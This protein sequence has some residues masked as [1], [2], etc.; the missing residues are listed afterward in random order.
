MAKVATVARHLQFGTAVVHPTLGNAASQWICRAPAR[1]TGKANSDQ[2]YKYPASI[3]T[4][5][6]PARIIGGSGYWTM[7]RGERE[8]SRRRSVQ[9]NADSVENSDDR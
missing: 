7:R 9:T 4:T 8:A 6:S 2:Y 1:D 5:A 3:P